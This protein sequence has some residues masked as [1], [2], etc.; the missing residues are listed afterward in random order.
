MRERYLHLAL[1][2]FF[3]QMLLI[4]KFEK[5]FCSLKMCFRIGTVSALYAIL[6]EYV[7]S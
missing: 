5:I 4:Y 7:G 2:I 1:L 6:D 3:K